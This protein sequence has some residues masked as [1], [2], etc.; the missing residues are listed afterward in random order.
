MSNKRQIILIAVTAV[1]LA[2]AI[3]IERKC[4]L[5]TVERHM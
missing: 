5:A 2:A 1:L 4:S 3:I